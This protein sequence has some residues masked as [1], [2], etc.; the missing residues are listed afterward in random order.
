MPIL[1][2][3]LAIAVSPESVHTMSNLET[4]LQSKQGELL[5]FPNN[6]ETY[7]DRSFNELTI[8]DQVTAKPDPLTGDLENWIINIP[9]KVREQLQKGKHCYIQIQ[10]KAAF[11]LTRPVGDDYLNPVSLD[12]E[13]TDFI[14]DH[15]QNIINMIEDTSLLSES[16]GITDLTRHLCEMLH[17]AMY[18]LADFTATIPDTATL[19]KLKQLKTLNLSNLNVFI[20]AIELY[21]ILQEKT[22][23]GSSMDDL[24]NFTLVHEHGVVEHIK[25][26]YRDTVPSSI[27]NSTD[28]KNVF[29]NEKPNHLEFNL[30]YPSL[31]VIGK[32]YHQKN[33]LNA[34]A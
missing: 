22:P 28:W 21:T 34:G 33:Q 4:L 9:A 10:E 26:F 30:C 6:R 14:A 7:V 16:L 12:E 29:E 11:F 2:P 19:D 13:F 25:S 15:Y 24:A 18:V 31:G 27:F 20:E 3:E 8:F 1:S 5:V 32:Y 17:S 23:Y